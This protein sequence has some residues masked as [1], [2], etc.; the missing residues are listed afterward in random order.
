MSFNINLPSNFTLPP[1]SLYNGSVPKEGPKAIPL[2]LTFAGA[3]SVSIDL[4][5]QKQLAKISG[6]QTI[7]IDN[8][9]N[10]HAVTIS[11]Q[12]TQQIIECPPSSQ[13]YFPILV[14]SD[15]K[16][17]ISSEGA[18]DTEFQF[19][20]FAIAGAV[21]GIDANTNVTYPFLFDSNGNL[22]TCNHNAV[23]VV[24]TDAS[25][26][27]TTGGTAQVALAANPN[28]KQYRIM[29]INAAT[30]TLWYRDDGGT[31]VIGGAGSW[32]LAGSASG[33]GGFAMGESTAAISVIATTTGHKF[34][35]VSD[36]GL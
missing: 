35:L 17:V 36:V 30:E 28:R 16:F 22:K 23:G 34:T 6:I 21:W 12:A 32:P 25:G 20:N 19:I 13:G 15:L 33:I 26:T 8:S 31:A 9:A 27:I 11:A 24:T 18:G 2:A 5:L 7:F 29:N 14:T 4:V 3:E 10:T 1:N